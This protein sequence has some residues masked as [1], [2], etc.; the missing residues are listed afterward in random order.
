MLSNKLINRNFRI[1][2]EKSKCFLEEKN[3]ILVK[4]K[5]ETDIFDGLLFKLLY[6]QKRVTQ[7]DVMKEINE[8]KNKFIDRTSYLDRSKLISEDFLC[9]YFKFLDKEINDIFFKERCNNTY[10]L[11]VISADG[12][13]SIA[14][15]S[16]KNKPSKKKNK[17]D[18]FTF[19]NMGMFNITYNEPCLLTSIEHKNER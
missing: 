18:T 11:P 3:K 5:K 14:Y 2:S 1:L 10:I 6:S 4:R 13:K 15:H 16:S 9:D 12:T 17:N 7:D 8:F 19:L